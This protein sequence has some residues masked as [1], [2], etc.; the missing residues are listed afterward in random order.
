MNVNILNPSRPSELVVEYATV[1]GLDLQH[2][3]SRREF[4]ETL[5]PED[6]FFLVEDAVSDAEVLGNLVDLF[7]FLTEGVGGV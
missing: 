5:L 4:L 7:K 6:L 2:V 1:Q 3:V